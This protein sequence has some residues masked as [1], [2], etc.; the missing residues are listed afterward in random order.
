MLS[1]TVADATGQ[2]W[3]TAFNDEAQKLI[4]I[5]ASEMNQIKQ[6]NTTEY[7][8]RFEALKF[9]Q[10]HIK[11]RA[12]NEVYQDEAKMRVA[13]VGISPI[14]YVTRSKE[15]IQLISAMA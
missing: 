6:V 10:Y 14:D 8:A 2:T 12:K 11:C 15:L 3:L 5:S 9:K 1:C 7:E 13:C 4:G